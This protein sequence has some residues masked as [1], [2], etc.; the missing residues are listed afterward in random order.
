LILLALTPLSPSTFALIPASFI[1][2]CMNRI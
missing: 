2:S 1:S